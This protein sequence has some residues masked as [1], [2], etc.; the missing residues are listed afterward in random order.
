[1]SPNKPKTPTRPIRVD[2]T[3]W[4]VFGEATNAMGT[5]RSAAFRAFME[6]YLHKPGTKA[7]TRPNKAAVEA[8]REAHLKKEAEK[9]AQA[10]EAQDG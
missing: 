6:W 3:D 8:A 1:M 5:D 7:P 4:G 2:L 9:A 10:K